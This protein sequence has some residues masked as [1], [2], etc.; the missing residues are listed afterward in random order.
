MHRAIYLIWLNC[1]NQFIDLDGPSEKIS[2]FVWMYVTKYLIWMDGWSQFYILVDA[3]DQLLD[4]DYTTEPFFF[5]WMD[6]RWPPYL[7]G[8]MH[9]TNFFI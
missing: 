3:L 4:F 7:S 2:R 5:I 1:W 6:G 9:G 8:R